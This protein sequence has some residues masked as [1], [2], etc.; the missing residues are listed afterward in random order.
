MTQSVL[1]GEKH[2][3]E[4]LLLH[5]AREWVIGLLCF[6]V[7]C[8]GGGWWAATV[9]LR[10]V[11]VSTMLGEGAVPEMTTYRGVQVA[12]ALEKLEDRAVKYEAILLQYGD[13]TIVPAPVQSQGGATST[14]SMLENPIATTT[15]EAVVPEIET[16]EPTS[17]IDGSEE[18]DT[19]VPTLA[20]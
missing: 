6:I 12:Q 20:L 5:P 7:L 10:Y 8:I 19:G 14:N 3:G 17:T 9:Y 4:H 1:R 16:I 15:V 13:K 2:Y 11:D 18:A